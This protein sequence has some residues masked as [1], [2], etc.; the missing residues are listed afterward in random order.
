MAEKQALVGL[1]LSAIEVLDHKDHNV[2]PPQMLFLQILGEVL[3]IESENKLV[4]EAAALLTRLFKDRSHRTCVLKGQGIARLY[5]Q[6][7]RRQPGDVDL[8]V[9]GGRRKTLKFLK[10]NFFGIGHVVIHHVDTRI[11]DGV[12]TEIHFIPCYSCNPILHRKLQR[13]FKKHSDEQFSNYDNTL[14]FAYPTLKFNAVYLLSH[15]YMHFLYEGIGL[16]QMVDYYYVLKN[17]SEEERRQAATDIKEVGLLKFAGAVMF[18]MQ[19]VCGM[20]DSLLVTKPDE[21]RG[22]LLL[23]EIMV[24]GNFGKYD[25]RLKGRDENNLIRFN[26]VALKRQL[27]FIRYYPLDIISI[28]FF[29]IWHWCWRKWNGYL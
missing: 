26:L 12:A 21:E 22:K 7:L 27:R 18:V 3:Q 5:P 28:P 24:S 6:P 20:D 29:K 16:R 8:W 15:I 10:D 13:F 17:L 11:V 23:N 1:L 14:R 19:R 4:D 25:E 9:E 2:K